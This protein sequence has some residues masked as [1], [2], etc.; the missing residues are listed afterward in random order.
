VDRSNYTYLK[1]ILSFRWIEIPIL[2]QF[3]NLYPRNEIFG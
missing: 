3:N 1:L 2:T